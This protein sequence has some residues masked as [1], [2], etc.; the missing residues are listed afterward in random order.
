MLEDTNAPVSIQWSGL[1][2]SQGGRGS[3][4]KVTVAYSPTTWHLFYVKVRKIFIL[5]PEIKRIII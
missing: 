4:L 1:P 3:H 2:F 5:K